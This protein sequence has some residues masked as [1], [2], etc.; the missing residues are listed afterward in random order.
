MEIGEL[1][2]D[3]VSRP[4]EAFNWKNIMFLPTAKDVWD[5]VKEMYSDSENSSQIL[6]IKS[7][8]WETKQ[9]KRNVIDYYLEMIVLLQELEKWQMII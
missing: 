5:A 6:K 3:Y 4:C 2:G 9:G 7:K 1:H 8:L